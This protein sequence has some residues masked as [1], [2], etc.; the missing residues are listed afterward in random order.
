[1]Q[2]PI[3]QPCTLQAYAVRVSQW[4]FISD[5]HT[6]EGRKDDTRQD[7]AVD[8]WQERGTGR[9]FEMERYGDW[10]VLAGMKG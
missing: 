1:M 4:E 2:Y 8:V 7:D 5:M 3:Y 10:T 9:G 6:M